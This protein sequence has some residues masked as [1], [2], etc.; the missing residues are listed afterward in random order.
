MTERLIVLDH[1]KFN[2]EGIFN[3]PEFYNLI[4]GFFFE[5]GYD[6]NEKI[7]Q[8]LVTPEGKQIRWVFEPW[9]NVSDY[10]QIIA[11]VRV[12]C[13]DVKEVDVEQEGRTLRLNQGVIFI[14]FDGF[15]KS[16]RHGKWESKPMYWLINILAQKY[17][18]KEHFTKNE[19][20]IKSDIDDL[21]N[22]IKTYLNV[23]KYAYQV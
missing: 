18:Y 13:S 14:T 23:F 20:W 4:S 5:K 9:K 8:E 12:N 10:Y 1:L 16:D 17:F 2:Y 6:W 15:V 7:N 11:R 19:D 3:L 21:H 22:K